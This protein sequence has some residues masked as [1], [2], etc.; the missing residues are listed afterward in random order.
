MTSVTPDG[1]STTCVL[2][3]QRQVVL[4][5]SQNTE[6]GIGFSKICYLTEIE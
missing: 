6:A 2:N 5:S 1:K 4:F 3:P